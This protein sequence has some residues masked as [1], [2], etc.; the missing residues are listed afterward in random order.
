VY[1]LYLLLFMGSGHYFIFFCA[2]VLPI[3]LAVRF[4]KA[5]AAQRGAQPAG[6]AGYAPNGY[7]PAPGYG[8]PGQFPQPAPGLLGR[9]TGAMTPVKRPNHLLAGAVWVALGAVTL[10]RVPGCAENVS[11]HCGR[12]RILKLPKTA[13]CQ[14]AGRKFRTDIPRR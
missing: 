5:R 1:G 9:F 6:P 2:F 13:G 14:F 12:R 4:F 8:Q 3:L 7:A 11:A 10:L